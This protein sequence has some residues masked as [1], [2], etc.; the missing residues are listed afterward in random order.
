MDELSILGID[1][2]LM[3]DWEIRSNHH[4]KFVSD[5]KPDDLLKTIDDNSLE[6]F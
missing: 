2:Y 5:I 6:P 3:D 1:D 4:V